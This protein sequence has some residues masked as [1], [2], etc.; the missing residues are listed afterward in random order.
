MVAHSIEL[1]ELLVDIDDML[2]IY[3]QI[4][5][6]LI[7]DLEEYIALANSPLPYEYLD[8]ICIDIWTDPFHIE[9]SFFICF[10]HDVYIL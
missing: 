1:I 5:L 4:L 3:T 10:H 9:R 7:H 8:D 6:E 2:S